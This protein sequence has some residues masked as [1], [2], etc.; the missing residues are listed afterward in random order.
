MKQTCDYCDNFIKD[1]DKVCPHCGAVNTHVVRSAKGVPKTI[2]EL[3]DYAVAHNLPLN[4]MRFFIGEDYRGARAFG[5]YE[6]NGIYTVY[7]NKAN[8]ERAVR[9]SGTDE[10]YA[11]NELYQKMHSEIM[12]RKQKK[13]AGQK[14]TGSSK[15]SNK[16]IDFIAGTI[17][18]F[19]VTFLHGLIYA[20]GIGL[21]GLIISGIFGSCDQKPIRG[22]YN[23]N[24]NVYYYQHDTW[25]D[26]DDAMGWVPITPV[27][28]L[29]DNFNDYYQGSGYDSGSEYSSF[30]DSDYYHPDSYWDDDD[31]WDDDSWDI[32]DSWDSGDTDWDSDW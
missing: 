15:K 16:F 7:K 11:V 3:K 32:N 26:Y 19:G 28:D 13:S 31:D 9:Y 10:A 22:Y 8:G 5:I 29:A 12:L 24:D 25:Y 4:K 2:Q 23:Y 17:G 30:S 18:C 21:V 20:A 27:S 6:Q 1:T 14:H